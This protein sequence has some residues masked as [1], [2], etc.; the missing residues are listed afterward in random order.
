MP[1]ISASVSALEMADGLWA[2]GQT[3]GSARALS[4]GW[5]IKPLCNA[6]KVPPATRNAAANN[7]HLLTM[8]IPF[9]AC[10]YSQLSLCERSHCHAK[11]WKSSAAIR[12]DGQAE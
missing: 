3:A 6:G 9:L 11:R 1:A 10:F 8:G 7:V 12:D 5:A 4:A 2:E